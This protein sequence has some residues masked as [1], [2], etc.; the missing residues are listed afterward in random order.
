MII[1]NN[2]LT[3]LTG[4]FNSEEEFLILKKYP[5]KREDIKMYQEANYF[6]IYKLY[7]RSFFMGYVVLFLGYN[8]LLSSDIAIEDI[9]FLRNEEFLQ[10]LLYQMLK[11]I[12]NMMNSD[13]YYNEAK[14]SSVYKEIFDSLGM[15]LLRMDICRV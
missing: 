13:F 11:K 4:K 6:Q 5:L 3:I 1:M 2:K 9:G 10:P 12:K 8:S 14:F 7:Y 15:N